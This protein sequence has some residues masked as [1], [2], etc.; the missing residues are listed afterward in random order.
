[1]MD[2]LKTY[3]VAI[4]AVLIAVGAAIQQYYAGESIDIQYLIEA[5]IALAMIFLRKGIKET[6][7]SKGE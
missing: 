4:A 6:L 1:M 7:A 3:M 2:G 5:L